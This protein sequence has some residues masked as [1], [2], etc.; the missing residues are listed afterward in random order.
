MK[1]FIVD[2]EGFNLSRGFCVKECAVLCTDNNEITH[3]FIRSPYHYNNLSVKDC[4]AVSFC[5]KAFHGIYWEAGRQKFS[6]LKNWFRENI[7][8]ND[9]IHC[10]GLEK[11]CFILNRLSIGSKVFNIEGYSNCPSFTSLSQEYIN[12]TVIACPLPFHQTKLSCSHKKVQILAAF[13]AD[14][15]NEQMHSEESQLL[16]NSIEMLDIE[17]EK[18]HNGSNSRSDESSC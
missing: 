4:K 17:K 18:T 6:D 8:P 1:T 14:Q 3:F 13:L 16:D 9:E 12:K 11:K 10:K 7:G 2:F 5:E 15:K